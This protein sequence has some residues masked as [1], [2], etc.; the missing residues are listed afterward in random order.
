MKLKEF[1]KKLEKIAK[2]HGDSIE[3]EMADEIPVVEPIIL[4]DFQNKKIVVITDQ[5]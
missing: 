1:I 4:K 5:K 3:V 2:Q